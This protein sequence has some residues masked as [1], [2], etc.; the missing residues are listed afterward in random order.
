MRGGDIYPNRE[1]G[2][3]IIDMTGILNAIERELW[4]KC[5]FKII[6]RNIL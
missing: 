1:W 5:Y 3:G 2:Y 6:S 4:R